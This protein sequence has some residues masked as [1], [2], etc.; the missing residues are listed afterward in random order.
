MRVLFGAI[1][2]IVVGTLVAVGACAMV[3]GN[4]F[5]YFLLIALAMMVIGAW[6]PGLR[7]S[8]A[9]S[10]GLLTLPALALSWSLLEQLFQAD[11]S[12]SEISF[13]PGETVQYGG[14]P[15][16]EEVLCTT[17]PGQLIVASAVL[18]AG[19]LIGA[20]I[21]LY[22]LWHAR[23]HEDIPAAQ[24][25]PTGEDASAVDSTGILVRSVA[26]LVGLANLAVLASQNDVADAYRRGDVTW[27]CVLPVVLAVVVAGLATSEIVLRWFGTPLTADRFALRYGTATFAVC[28]GG[29]LMGFLL[30][31]VLTLERALVPGP[32]S[33]SELVLVAFVLGIVGAVAGGV[34]GA[35]E[36]L[37]LAFPLAAILGRFRQSRGQDRGASLPALV[38]LCLLVIAALVSSVAAPPTVPSGAETASLSDNPPLSCPEYLG[39]EIGVFDGPGDQKTPV[40]ETTGDGWGYQSS[41][42]GPGS[43]K[44]SVLD[45]DGNDMEDSGE[46]L[47]EDES[48]RGGSVSMA[49][50]AFSGAF[51]LQIDADDDL[52]YQVLVCD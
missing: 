43:L 26:V 16:G 6:Q 15:S 14:G 39:E 7:Y 50:F 30:A 49:E 1:Y 34:M 19:P 46:T 13:L 48:L 23:S 22:L 20:A 21:L 51:S 44:I 29:T 36:G 5:P 38:I 33:I 9:A 17:I 8:W 11:W 24:S 42:A 41:S 2:W 25:G 32:P 45:G 3:F 31:F 47:P 27:D 12:C 4:L 52:D 10:V 37:I 28:L 40:F 18:W 35:L